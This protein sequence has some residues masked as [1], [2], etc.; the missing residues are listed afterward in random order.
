MPFLEKCSFELCGDCPA[1]GLGTPNR[2]NATPQRDG[3]TQI[4]VLEKTNNG[5]RIPL[6][7]FTVEKPISAKDAVDVVL[8]R[9]RE[10]GEHGPVET[11]GKL[12]FGRVVQCCITLPNEQYSRAVEL[13]EVTAE[14]LA[15]EPTPNQ[16]AA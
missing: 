12:G 9:D 10:R 11:T 2:I 6:I 13:V 7:A 1:Q 8:E 16:V 3:T 4:D 5:T 14:A 15:P